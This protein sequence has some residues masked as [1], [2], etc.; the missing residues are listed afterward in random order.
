MVQCSHTHAK[1]ILSEKKL[2][3]HFA[4][5]SISNASDS[6]SFEGDLA[7]KGLSLLLLMKM[8]THN[9]CNCNAQSGIVQC[10]VLSTK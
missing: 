5:I 6:E 8:C 4:L 7:V 10:S 2:F 9:E 3:T 1:Y